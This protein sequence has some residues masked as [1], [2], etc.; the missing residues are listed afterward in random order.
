MA[1]VR[2]PR[3]LTRCA[4]VAKA[5]ALDVT[6]HDTEWGVP[7]HN[8][9]VLFEFLILEGAQAGLSWSTVL[10]KRENYRR[11]LAG[12]D[13]ARIARF[14]AR[15]QTRL[16]AN[17]GIIRN[18]LKITATIDNARAFLAIQEQ[19]GSFAEYLW[20]FVDGRPIQNRFREQREVPAKT[21][22]SDALS[23]DLK[24]R[25]CR[26]VGTT[27]VYAYMQAVGLVNDHLVDCFRCRAV[28]RLR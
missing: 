28:A 11:A 21:P 2:S 3:A 22:L 26:F 12:F 9:R 15:D 17:P 18:R 6:Y 20:R 19:F 24:A 1:A 4:W 10:A 16:L 23:K 25:G 7:V 27:I 13:P 5:G 8:D 14:G